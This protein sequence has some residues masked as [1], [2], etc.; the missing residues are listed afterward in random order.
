M[1]NLNLAWVAGFFDG[2]GCVS[3]YRFRGRPK[4]QVSIA[5]KDRTLLDLIAIEFPESV[6]PSFGD[7]VWHLFF[8]GVKARGF[9]EAIRPYSLGKAAQIDM[10]LRY[11][12]LILP[13]NGRA[14]GLPSDNLAEREVLFRLAKEAK[15]K[16]VAVN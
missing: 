5:Q 14:H 1:V 13:A 8:N 10:A 4:M 2:E 3:I 6:G 15:G 12:G 7:G 11:I 16:A 9:L